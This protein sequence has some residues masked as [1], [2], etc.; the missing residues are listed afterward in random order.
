MEQFAAI[1]L[2][3]QE[4]VLILMA[5]TLLML[6]I[7]AIAAYRRKKAEGVIE[8]KPSKLQ[9]ASAFV[10]IIAILLIWGGLVYWIYFSNN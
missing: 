1:P 6:A 2:K 7:I 10:A 3:L 8:E 4:R 5:P 9:K